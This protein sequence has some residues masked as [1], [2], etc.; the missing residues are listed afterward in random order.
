MLLKNTNDN[1]DVHFTASRFEYQ[2]T[3]T[4][5]REIHRVNGWQGE[6]ALE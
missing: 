2:V 6:S 1:H 4:V 5:S 3:H